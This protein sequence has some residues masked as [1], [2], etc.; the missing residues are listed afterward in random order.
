MKIASLL[1]VT[2]LL[3]LVGGDY[4]TQIAP[5]KN[6]HAQMKEHPDVQAFL[7]KFDKAVET[8]GSPSG[9]RRFSAGYLRRVD[10]KP[11]FRVIHDP[12]MGEEIIATGPRA[13]LD[14]MVM[15]R[16]DD[17]LSPDFNAP[18]R[19]GTHVEIRI[20]LERHTDSYFRIN[21]LRGGENSLN[22]LPDF[23]TDGPFRVPFLK[24]AG[25]PDHPIQVATNDL[26]INTAADLDNLHG[27]TVN[28]EY[29]YENEV[30]KNRRANNLKVTGDVLFSDVS[31]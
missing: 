20:N 16:D 26:I 2:G 22:L 29:F 19:L 30:Q 12:T 17:R 14:L 3:L 5:K 8:S 6:H 7:A 28:L 21:L 1:F 25:L 18:V 15:H 31:E 10:V 24:V 11:G 4:F 27:T 23:V 9:E 13:A